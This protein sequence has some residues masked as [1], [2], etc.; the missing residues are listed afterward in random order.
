MG[1]E[2]ELDDVHIGSRVIA[3]MGS[4]Q[5]GFP[6][7]EPR[8]DATFLVDVILRQGLVGPFF[9]GTSDL[10]ADVNTKAKIGATFHK[11]KA[12]LLGHGGEDLQ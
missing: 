2:K 4:T 8:G 6:F 11:F 10:V 1:I 9:V 5:K 7:A 3:P 12:I